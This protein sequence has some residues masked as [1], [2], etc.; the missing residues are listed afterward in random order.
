M[1]RQP[2][3][4]DERRGALCDRCG[5][6]TDDGIWAGHRYG[7]QALKP[8][9][10]PI[11]V[12]QKPYE[13][14]P[15]D[16]ITRTG[17]GALNVDGA[18]IATDAP[19]AAHRG[20]GR[21]VAMQGNAEE[22][23]PEPYKTGDAGPENTQS[24][25]R[26]PANFALVHHPDCGEQCVEGCPVAALD[27]QTPTSMHARGNKTA[28]RVPGSAFFGEA[29][30]IE[31][32]DPGDSGSAAR[33]FYSGDWQAE[34]L[35]QADPVLYAA[36]ASVSEREAGLHLDGSEGRRCT[37]PTVK[38]IALARWLATLLLPPEQ[39]APRRILIP[40]SGVASEMI[41]AGLA[42][43]EY[44]QGVELSKEYAE[45]GAIRLEW[46]MGRGWQIPLFGG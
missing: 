31:K 37:H 24:L 38:P 41:G 20:T 5:L 15:V 28:K 16:D 44:V 8:A 2:L 19:I 36:K 1:A 46:W 34:A 9:A 14:R 39:Y 25:G 26:W 3:S 42:G 45:L 27:S 6:P 43:W 35:E 22:S 18:R 32:G 17:A 40:F 4:Q 29:D 7:L 21:G 10:E 13:G 23:W 11:I 33:F 30:T 12:F